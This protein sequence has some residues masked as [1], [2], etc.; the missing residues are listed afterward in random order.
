MLKEKLKNKEHMNKQEECDPLSREK[1]KQQM[2][3]S[4]RY[5]YQ[6][7]TLHGYIIMLNEVKEC[8]Q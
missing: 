8:M 1:N 7:R 2:P 3:N 4:K 6:T 5:D